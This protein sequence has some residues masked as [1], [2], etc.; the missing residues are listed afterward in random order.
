MHKPQ[1]HAT[2]KVPRQST[3]PRAGSQPDDF[4]DENSITQKDPDTLAKEITD[5]LIKAMREQLS[6]VDVSKF[7][8]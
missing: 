1:K 3:V 4:V 8:K 2:E 6:K 5:P 7:G